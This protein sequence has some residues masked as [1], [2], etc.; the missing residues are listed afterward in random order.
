MS[1]TSSQCSASKIYKGMTG[2]RFI[3]EGLVH[4][5]I[6]NIR[7]RNH[8]TN[9]G[10]RATFTK[11]QLEGDLG[12]EAGQYGRFETDF[13]IPTMHWQQRMP[14][15]GWST[16]WEEVQ[17]RT[18]LKEQGFFVVFPPRKG[19]TKAFSILCKRLQL[20]LW[21]VRVLAAARVSSSQKINSLD[22]LVV[23]NG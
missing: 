17:S 14:L 19:A 7:Q 23:H 15:F 1:T 2:L 9:K 3:E 21:L 6:T 10:Y 22:S 5:C 8:S 13:L 18:R 12:A 11:A 4:M 16:H 20:A